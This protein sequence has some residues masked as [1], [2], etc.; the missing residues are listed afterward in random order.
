MR[1]AKITH[2]MIDRTKQHYCNDKILT[3]KSEIRKYTQVN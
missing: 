2:A 3:C 1:Y